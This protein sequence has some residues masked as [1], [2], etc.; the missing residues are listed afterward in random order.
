MSGLPPLALLGKEEELVKFIMM[1]QPLIKN[2]IVNLGS[3]IPK[4]IEWLSGVKHFFGPPLSPMK[5]EGA[6]NKIFVNLFF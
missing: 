1:S 3:Y 6:K 2:H 5:P 4:A